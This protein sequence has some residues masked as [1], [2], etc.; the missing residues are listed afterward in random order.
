MFKRANKLSCSKW[1][2]KLIRKLVGFEKKSK[3]MRIKKGKKKE[4][5]NKQ[6]N[7]DRVI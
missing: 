6:S 3:N 2:S 4:K 7:K 1:K 5:I